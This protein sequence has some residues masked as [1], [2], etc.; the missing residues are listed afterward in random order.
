M[1]FRRASNVYVR[2][3]KTDEYNKL[4]NK[5]YVKPLTVVMERIPLSTTC[6][7]RF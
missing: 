7:R 2:V 6:W 1:K 4:E 5:R 3:K